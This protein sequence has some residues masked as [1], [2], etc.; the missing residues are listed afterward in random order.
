MAEPP[1]RDNEDDERDRRF[2]NIFLLVTF[3]VVVGVGVWL[4]NAMIDYRRIDDC[5]SQGRRNCEPLDVS[6]R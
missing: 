1:N 5:M 4:V 3:V 6:P 2:T